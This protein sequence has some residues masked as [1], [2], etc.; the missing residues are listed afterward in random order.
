LPD[1]Q[2]YTAQF[3]QWSL[4]AEKFSNIL[5]KGSS[6]AQPSNTAVILIFGPVICGKFITIQNHP[7]LQKHSYTSAILHTKRFSMKVFGL[8]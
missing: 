6:E 3:N 2:L 7:D 1:D 5:C 4:S 8:K